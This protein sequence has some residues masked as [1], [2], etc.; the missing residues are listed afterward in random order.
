[1][2]PTCHV[3]PGLRTFVNYRFLGGQ[4]IKHTLISIKIIEK[5]Y[6]KP[7]RYHLK[8]HNIWDLE[9]IQLISLNRHMISGDKILI[10][11]CRI[12]MCG[13]I[14]IIIP[15]HMAS[16]GHNA[17]STRINLSCVT[18]EWWIAMIP[19]LLTLCP[20]LVDDFTWKQLMNVQQN[21]VALLGLYSPSSA[22]VLSP[23]LMSLLL[24]L[25]SS[26]LYD[27]RQAQI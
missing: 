24:M 25:K 19:K 6:F 18:T 13:N 5:T 16:L 22:G 3:A 2:L 7:N 10:C 15:W 26:Y 21:P 12:S 14:W 17:I 4:F 20:C 23:D 27:F 11:R 1:M 8:L 9:N